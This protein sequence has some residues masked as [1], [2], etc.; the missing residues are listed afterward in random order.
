ME[1]NLLEGVEILQKFVSFKTVNEPGDEKPLAEYIKVLLDEIGLETK[2]D[3]LGNNRANVI[4]RLKGKR[5]RKTLLFNGHLDTVPSGDME[6][7][8]EPYIGHIEDGKIYGRGTA[9][10]KGGLAAMLVAVKAIKKSGVELKG[11]FLYT[12]TAGEETDSI[13]AVKF[14]NDGGLDEV[15]AIIIGEPCSGKINIAEKGAF[16]VEIT[17]YGKTAHGAFPKEGVNA[18]IHMNALISEI[19]SYRFKYKENPI[20]GHPTMNISTIRGGVKTNV[21]PDRCSI[22][23]DMRTVPG[24]NHNDIIQDFKKLILKLSE[25]I[26]GF[27]A[28]IRILNNRP[29]VETIKTHPF[30]KLAQQTYKEVFGV[31]TEPQ[32]V[33]FYTDASIFLPAKSVPCIFFGP[34]DSS[35]A[36]QPNEYITLESFD[37]TVKYYIRLIENYLVK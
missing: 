32:G 25:E 7:K 27:K 18:V 17:T 21:V 35:M 23:I 9:D 26:K 19:L 10:M 11:D 29:A 16:W 12:A 4:G 5:E 34:G 14:V 28:D 15:G 13:G 30:I 22:T 3:D 31:D 24:M 37:Q 8:H 6:W 20:V 36:H 33:D 2:I 1:N